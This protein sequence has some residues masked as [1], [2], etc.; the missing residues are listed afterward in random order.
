[1]MKDGTV[2][3]SRQYFSIEDIS[4]QF[5]GTMFLYIIIFDALLS[6]FVENAEGKTF[7]YSQSKEQ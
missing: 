7:L 3:L 2:N 1:M 4:L 5:L 6:V